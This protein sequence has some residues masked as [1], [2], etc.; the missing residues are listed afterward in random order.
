MAKIFNNSKGFKVIEISRREM[1]DNLSKYGSAG[2]CDMCI[3][4][5]ETGD[6]V[7]VLNMWLCRECLDA[8]IRSSKRY[9]EDI[10]V[11]ERNF[12]LYCKIFGVDADL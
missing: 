7:A 10:P 6:Y 2:I 11:E 12:K 5:P 8:F 9:D 3:D 4:A 1:L